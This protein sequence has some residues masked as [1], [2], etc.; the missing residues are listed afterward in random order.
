MLSGQLCPLGNLIAVLVF[1]LMCSNSSFIN[2]LNYLCSFT[3]SHSK[4][5]LCFCWRLELLMHND[6]IKLKQFEL[7]THNQ[8]PT[9]K[10]I[11]FRG[12]IMTLW[13]YANRKIAVKKQSETKKNLAN[14]SWVTRLQ[15]MHACALIHLFL[16]PLGAR[17]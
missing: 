10:L 1:L 3:N 15:L 9:H 6:S 5:H 4:Q 16:V 7:I 13:P 11:T 14:N 2:S 17:Q 8:P 12:T